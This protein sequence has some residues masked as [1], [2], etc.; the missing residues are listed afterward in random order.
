[1]GYYDYKDY[2]VRSIKHSVIHYVQRALAQTIFARGDDIDKVTIEEM[3]LLDQ[4]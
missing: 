4:I 1:M 2:W 3:K